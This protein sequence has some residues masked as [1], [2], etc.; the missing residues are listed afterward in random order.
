MAQLR[1]QISQVAASLKAASTRS[2]KR[3]RDVD[4]QQLGQQ[5]QSGASPSA[6]QPRHQPR[7]QGTVLRSGLIP[8]EELGSRSRSRSRSREAGAHCDRRGSS[9]A[10]AA[11]PAPYRGG[12]SPPRVVSPDARARVQQPRASA[13]PE[14]GERTRTPQ[15]R[16]S[17]RRSLRSPDRAML[18]EFRVRAS[19]DKSDLVSSAKSRKHHCYCS[20]FLKVY[21]RSIL[22]NHD[23]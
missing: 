20:C 23:I 17:P 10:V 8:R 16:R 22:G 4:Q 11:A 13:S 5:Q 19:S 2:A 7:H 21:Y 18:V 9:P 1:Q 6:V 14:H 15:R 12:S 3:L